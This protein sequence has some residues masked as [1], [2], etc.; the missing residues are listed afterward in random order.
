M[1][2]GTGFGSGFASSASAFAPS[3][4]T[5][6]HGDKKR[7][8]PPATTGAAAAAAEARLTPFKRREPPMQTA[9]AV[10]A[11]IV[12]ASRRID[13]PERTRA[14]EL[15]TDAH[16]FF[17]ASFRPSWGPGGRLIHAGRL[18]ASGAAVQGAVGYASAAERAADQGS[19]HAPST[20]VTVERFAPS[21]GGGDAAGKRAALEVALAHTVSVVGGAGAEETGQRGPSTPGRT[22]PSTSA[23][24]AAAADVD[25]AAAADT[26]YGPL[27]RFECTR[28]ELP[29]LCLRHLAAVETAVASGAV[30][31]PPSELAAEV[32]AWDLL[33][34]EAIYSLHHHNYAA[35]TR[36]FYSPFTTNEKPPRICLGL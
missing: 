33:S 28:L 22:P 1:G 2:P 12:G 11:S 36:L 17:G 9:Y 29:S 16:S 15:L 25:A 20:S 5:G 6:R 7:L 10:A 4:F 13:L 14:P 26:E 30:E 24:A 3:A 21:R 27:L 34:V 35:L 19:P 31:A 8:P 18:T 32:G 23:A